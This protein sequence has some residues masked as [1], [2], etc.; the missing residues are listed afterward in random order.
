MAEIP[1]HLLKRAQEAKARATTGGDSSP[2]EATAS[3]SKIP[4]ELLNRTAAA[5]SQPSAVATKD[6]SEEITSPQPPP[7]SATG[8]AGHTQRLLAVVKSGSIQ[9]VKLKPVDKV[10]VWPH[11][12]VVEFVAALAVTAF[13][14]VF[15]IFVNAPLLELAN[16]NKLQI[17]QKHLGIS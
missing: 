10:H 8:P 9:D 16:F 12:L 11:L 2:T 4:E 1:E 3:E 14:V 17:H 6:A 15:S 5:G 7:A 13:C